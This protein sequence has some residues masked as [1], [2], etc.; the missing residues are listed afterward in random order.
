MKPTILIEN[1][2]YEKIMFWVNRSKDEV[3]GLGTIKVEKDGILRVISAMLL[4]QTNT[5]THTEI[6]A[7]GVNKAM[8]QLRQAEGELKFW[9][10][11]HVMMGVFWSGTDHATIKEF[12]THDWILATVFNQKNEMRSAY[13]DPKG[14]TTPWGKSELFYDECITRIAKP[15]TYDTKEWESEYTTN[16]KPKV[17]EAPVYDSFDTWRKRDTKGKFK[18]TT[19]EEREAFAR[20]KQGKK[21]LLTQD[22]YDDYCF[23]ASERAFIA[24]HGLTDADLDYLISE[25]FT[26][27]NILTLFDNEAEMEEIKQLLQ[28]SRTP[29]EIMKTLCWQNEEQLDLADYYAGFY[30]KGAL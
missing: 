10:H 12:G 4:P 1:E 7:E 20:K 21:T 24:E 19:P 5:A 16:V 25:G 8:Y 26:P 23:D 29:D 11:S 3:S 22:E 6:T 18:Q 30:G 28:Q 9:W 17:Y 15:V 2:V 27:M 13:Y 14:V